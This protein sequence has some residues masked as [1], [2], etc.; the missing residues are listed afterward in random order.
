MP[1]INNSVTLWQYLTPKL[2]LKPIIECYANVIAQMVRL[3]VIF[4]TIHMD[5]HAS[6]ILIK[7]HE[8]HIECLLIDF[9]RIIQIDQDIELDFIKQKYEYL[10]RPRG[11]TME[12]KDYEKTNYV[13]TVMNYIM[14]IVG[15]NNGNPMNWYSN[16]ILLKYG[17]EF[18]REPVFRRAFDIL[19]ASSIV[20][21]D[22]VGIS[23]STIKRYIKEGSLFNPNTYSY[24][25]LYVN[26]SKILGIPIDSPSEIL[27]IPIDS[28]TRKSS[29]MPIIDQYDEY[30]KYFETSHS[31][32]KCQD[33][34]EAGCVISGGKPKNRKSKTKKNRKNKSKTRTKN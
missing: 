34:E 28:P 26:K 19:H 16:F 7:D 33:N 11:H 1:K 18:I 23:Y 2:S 14:K 8:Q 32:K 25:N 17:N 4:K 22:R 29:S 27:G 3:F 24:S 12:F 6:N 21:I 13:V 15:E 10:F 30:E 9:G 20:D 5:L 31:K